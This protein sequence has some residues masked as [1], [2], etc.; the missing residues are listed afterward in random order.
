MAEPARVKQPA[1][2]SS[3]S[4]CEKL[5]SAGGF[6]RLSWQSNSETLAVEWALISSPS[7][8]GQKP[9][10]IVNAAL[11]EMTEILQRAGGSAGRLHVDRR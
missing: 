5:K 10:N 3:V 6:C 11:K 9:V 8:I 1:L 7:D 4:S 2:L